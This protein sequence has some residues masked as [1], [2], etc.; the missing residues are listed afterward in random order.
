MKKYV[1]EFIKRGFMAAGGGPVVLAIVYGC[2][3]IS[4]T[5]EFLTPNEV[6]MGVLSVT[7]MAFIVGGIGVIYTV[8]SLPLPM[9][10]L[11]HVGVL[12]LDY[13]LVY[14]FNNWLPKQAIGVFTAAFAIGYA[15]IWMI[16]YLRVRV[17][18]KKLNAKIRQGE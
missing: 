8:E 18:T 5:V 7:L 1:L 10:I 16:I 3:G 4:G 14:L 13:L 6:C 9:A 15:F 17:K 12:Y 2:L 11:I